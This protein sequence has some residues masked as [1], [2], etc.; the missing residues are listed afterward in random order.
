MESK[1]TIRA[2]RARGSDDWLLAPPFQAKH[3]DEAGLHE[4]EVELD[5]EFRKE[6]KN[7]LHGFGSWQAKGLHVLLRFRRHQAL[8]ASLFVLRGYKIGGG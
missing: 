1:P 2:S 4:V 3:D 5:L 7:D 6:L 8:A